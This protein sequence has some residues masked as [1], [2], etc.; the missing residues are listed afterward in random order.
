[1]TLLSLN[2][3]FEMGRGILLQLTKYQLRQRPLRFRLLVGGMP[4]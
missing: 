1:M 4:I 2:G 3:L